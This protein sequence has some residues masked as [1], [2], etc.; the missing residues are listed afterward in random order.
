VNT[1]VR[2]ALLIILGLASIGLIAYSCFSVSYAS[3]TGRMSEYRV[4]LLSLTHDV[5]HGAKGKLVD[6]TQSQDEAPAAQTPA[7]VPVSRTSARHTG[8]AEPN[9]TIAPPAAPVSGLK[10]RNTDTNADKTLTQHEAAKPVPIKKPAPKKPVPKKKP[11][12]KKG[13]ACPT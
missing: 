12:K 10:S 2:P 3:D 4:T 8:K 11:G 1:R 9:P 5:E 6:L 13:K 7:A